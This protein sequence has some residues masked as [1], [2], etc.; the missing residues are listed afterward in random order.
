ML[1]EEGELVLTEYFYERIPHYAVLSHTWGPDSEEVS[2]RDMEMGT[3]RMKAGYKK[4][5]WIARQARRD[6]LVYTW[7]DTCCIDKT[8]NSELSEAI[9]SM[10]RWYNE[11]VECYVYLADVPSR[12]LPLQEGTTWD[13]V[14]ERSRWFTRGW[15]LQ[16]MIAP[17]IVSF[18]SHDYEYLGNKEDFE[19]QINNTT[20]I[21]VAVLRGAKLDQYS[22][23][24]RMSWSHGRRTKRIEDG[25]YCLLGI[26]GIFMPLIYGEGKNAFKR[27]R[28]HIKPT[29][30]GKTFPREP[31]KLLANTRL[32]EMK[33]EA[34]TSNSENTKDYKDTNK[35][36]TQIK[37]DKDDKK[38]LATKPDNPRRK[39][40]FDTERVM[41]LSESEKASAAEIVVSNCQQACMHVYSTFAL[42]RCKYDPKD[43]DSAPKLFDT[44]E[45]T[46]PSDYARF[47]LQEWLFKIMLAY[48]NAY[49][50]PES[51]RAPGVPSFLSENGRGINL[52]IVRVRVALR[53]KPHDR[54]LMVENFEIQIRNA[55]VLCRAF[56]DIES[57][58]RV[59]QLLQM[60]NGNDSLVD[61]ELLYPPPR[62]SR[63]G[64][65]SPAMAALSR[66]SSS[67]LSEVEINVPAKAH[68]RGPLE[69]QRDAPSHEG[70]LVRSESHERKA[71]TG[72][73]RDEEDES[74][75]SVERAQ[76]GSHDGEDEDNVVDRVEQFGGISL[77]GN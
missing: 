53:E 71:E 70:K 50:P 22:V 67:V 25:A 42:W 63:S 21:P 51:I 2:F 20:G 41:S 54:K 43:P 35:A 64:L 5:L 18:Y 75:D 4:L 52:K 8:N 13:S 44:P 6:G 76:E 40:T 60:L 7:V 11:A 9:T 73:A 26:F 47:T 69:T 31:P 30:M 19:Q 27:L 66:R 74:F 65:L 12:E 16:E 77:R 32:V 34:D 14:F 45:G 37:Q 29:L 23:E 39:F 38:T 55:I 33:T 10:Y 62:Y 17:S 49:L 72:H 28:E 68:G 59:E 3:G 36:E 15:T 46:Q 58:F 24:E 48:D 56:G 61:M 1:Q 57:T